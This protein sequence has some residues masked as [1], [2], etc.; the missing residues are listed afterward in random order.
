MVTEQLE[1]YRGLKKKKNYFSMK[2]QDKYKIKS[3]LR[4]SRIATGKKYMKQ[5]DRRK[6]EEGILV[7]KNLTEKQENWKPK[8][9][10]V[11]TIGS[12]L[13]RNKC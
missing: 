7:L 6:V 10:E 1:Y 8:T 4:K 11:E 9:K 12:I 13:G 2:A 5:S 3:L